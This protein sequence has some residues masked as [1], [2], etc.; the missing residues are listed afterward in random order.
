MTGRLKAECYDRVGLFDERL[1]CSADW[2]MWMRMSRNY[3]F[4][5]LDEPLVASRQR[6][7]SLTTERYALSR[8]KASEIILQSFRKDLQADRN[9]LAR[10]HVK[11]ARNY[12]VSGLRTEARRG[13]LRAVSADPLG[14]KNLAIL[15]LLLFGRRTFQFVLQVKRRLF[16]SPIYSCRSE[17]IASIIP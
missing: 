7:D 4:G 12:W 1:R 16:G 13:M 10:I 11:I 5:Y 17:S 6:P 15:V 8:A 3:R 14:L 9:A 2:Q